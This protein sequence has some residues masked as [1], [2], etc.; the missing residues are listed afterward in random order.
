MS[1]KQ[2]PA[3]E[4]HLNWEK[5]N[6]ILVPRVPLESVKES[7]PGISV[8]GNDKEAQDPI[9]YNSSGNLFKNCPSDDDNEVFPKFS[10][11]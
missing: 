11:L 8:N 5:Y 7:Y 4:Y 2:T 1:T 3:F 9:L 6:E 10:L